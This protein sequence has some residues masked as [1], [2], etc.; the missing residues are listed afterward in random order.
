L[1]VLQQFS[2]I[3]SRIVL[4]ATVYFLLLNL[5]AAALFVWGE[6]TLNDF[7]IALQL[8]LV[9]TFFGVI[10]LAYIANWKGVFLRYEDTNWFL[11]AIF[12]A[13]GILFQFVVLYYSATVLPS[14]V[15]AFYS[16][17][18]V[19]VPFFAAFTENAFFIG[20]IADYFVDFFA[21][22]FPRH[23]AIIL[24]SIVGGLA[25]GLVS[26]LFHMGRYGPAELIMVFF[27]FFWW[28]VA[29]FLSGSTFYADFHH[30]IG[31]AAGFFRN[32]VEV[33]PA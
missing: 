9:Q 6:L 1:N 33:I 20:V 23:V 21:A 14:V 3:H 16:F 22:H 31:N 11:A 2:D 12:A 19:F 17:L 15:L 28:S 8:T 4:F 24:G 26:A 29:S 30:A 10:Y 32:V 13:L 25:A 18:F 7:V 27:W 5:L